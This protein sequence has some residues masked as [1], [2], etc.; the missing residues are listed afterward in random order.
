MRIEKEK[1][2]QAVAKEK[3]N[4]KKKAKKQEENHLDIK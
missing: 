2:E 3:K 4:K 1:I